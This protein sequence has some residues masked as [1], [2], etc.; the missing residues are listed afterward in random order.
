M[1]AVF[2]LVIDDVA[3]H[4]FVLIEAPGLAVAIVFSDHVM[5]SF[6]GSSPAAFVQ[7]GRKLWDDNVARILPGDGTVTEPSPPV[8]LAGVRERMGEG[9][10]EIRRT[11]AYPPPG[12]PRRKQS[13]RSLGA[14]NR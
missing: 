11:P 10:S 8:T 12:L 3:I 13:G 14:C 2:G 5:H 6:Q 4:H 7:Q 1:D 9:R